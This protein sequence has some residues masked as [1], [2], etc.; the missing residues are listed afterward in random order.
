[1]AAASCNITEIRTT[2]E[3]RC[4][5]RRL[6]SELEDWLLVSRDSLEEGDTTE[7]R[8]FC[9]GGGGEGGRRRREERRECRR[10][11]EREGRGGGEG[12]EGGEGREGGKSGGKRGR[13]ERG[14]REHYPSCHEVLVVKIAF[15][16]FLCNLSMSSSRRCFSCSKSTMSWFLCC[17]NSLDS[18]SVF[19]FSR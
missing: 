17:S 18:F 6:D 11:E 16:L 7:S 10:R 3:P 13:E 19:I 14:V 8:T 15:T 5:R 9:R 12:G 2:S 4:I 1:M